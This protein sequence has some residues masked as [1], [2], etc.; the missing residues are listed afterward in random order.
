MEYRN[1]IELD[2]DQCI[3]LIDVAGNKSIPIEEHNSNILCLDENMNL[4]WRISALAGTFERD[5]FVELKLENDGTI[6]ARR[7]FGNTYTV[8]ASTG[9]AVQS[10]WQK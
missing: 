2:S 6:T 4:L 3:V 8:N 1:K 5:S 7:F 10:G 9:V